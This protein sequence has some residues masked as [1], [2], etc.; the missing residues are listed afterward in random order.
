MC[1]CV[2]LAFIISLF[3]D[4]FCK[5][6]TS[7]IL[8]VICK[9]Y[10]CRIKQTESVVSA[11]DK[12]MTTH[13]LNKRDDDSFI[14]FSTRGIPVLLSFFFHIFSK[15]NIII[16]I[17]CVNLCHTQRLFLSIESRLRMF[18]CYPDFDKMT[19]WA[20]VF[21]IIYFHL[22]PSHVFNHHQSQLVFFWYN[23]LYRDFIFTN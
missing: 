23:F 5:I 21:I 13:S 7:G 14:T 8:R 12:R 11:S 3:I 6:P 16:I 2:H 20:K 15:T 4:I 1:V 9:V 22:H 19:K 10:K 18:F 17:T